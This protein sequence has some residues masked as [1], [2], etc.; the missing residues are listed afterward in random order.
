[1]KARRE[2]QH[3]RTDPDSRGWAWT[4]VFQTANQA[5]DQLAK[6]C[7]KRCVRTRRRAETQAGR[8]VGEHRRRRA[9]SVMGG[10]LEVGI[11][12]QLVVVAQARDRFDGRLRK[13]STNQ[14]NVGAVNACRKQIYT[15][16][17]RM[18]FDPP[19]KCRGCP[20]YAVSGRPEPRQAGTAEA[21]LK[22]TGTWR[23]ADKWARPKKTLPKRIHARHSGD[24]GW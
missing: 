9:R 2:A 14:N 4:I 1:M 18:Q 21:G 8:R 10:L 5:T 7:V 12:C 16:H 17:T 22:Q 11:D 3:R 19:G 13:E 23:R 15:P 20:G 24:N 6:R